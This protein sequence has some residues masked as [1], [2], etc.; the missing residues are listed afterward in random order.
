M[1]LNGQCRS[2]IFL[3]EP[4][5]RKEADTS[6]KRNGSPPMMPFGLANERKLADDAAVC[7]DKRA[8]HADVGG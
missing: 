1:V 7:F 4:A 3:G 5:W 2:A 8:T 6:R